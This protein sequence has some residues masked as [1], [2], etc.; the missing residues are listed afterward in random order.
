MAG[1]LEPFKTEKTWNAARGGYDRSAVAVCSK[2]GG[3]AIIADNCAKARPPV[4][5][6]DKFRRKGWR[7]GQRR[8]ADVCP[9][10]I[11]GL[12]HH[13]AA[14]PAE[15]LQTETPKEAIMPPK[16]VKAVAPAAADVTVEPP[17]QPTREEV[18]R[19]RDA[20]DDCYLLD[21]DC[22][23]GSNTDKSVAERLRVPRAWVTAE[24][25]HAYGPDRCEDDGRLTAVLD[26]LEKTAREQEAKALE[27]GAAFERLRTDIAAAKAAIAARGRA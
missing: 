15:P 11:A 20:L 1:G 23:A 16:T 25:E 3:S 8:S 21:R 10:C 19:I 26:G 6:A 18:R 13:S 7:M 14:T 2:C 17:R 22:Y 5:F 4:F 9:G 27:L 12:T 24:R